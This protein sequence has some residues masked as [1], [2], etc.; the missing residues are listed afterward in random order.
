MSVLQVF[1]DVMPEYARSYTLIENFE[2]LA[3]SQPFFESTN[4]RVS[5]FQSLID[6]IDEELQ[7]ESRSAYYDYVHRT[8]AYFTFKGVEYRY[9]LGFGWQTG[10]PPFDEAEEDEEDKSQ[11]DE[12]EEDEDEEADE[13][14]HSQHEEKDQDD[15]LSM[16]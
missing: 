4:D 11:D 14:E 1:I 9:E 3:A 16:R 2:S 12:E 6:N 5:G 8:W 15:D 7:A 13:E 10:R